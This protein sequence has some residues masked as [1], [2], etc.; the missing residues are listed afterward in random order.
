M[1]GREVFTSPCSRCRTPRRGA[2]GRS[3]GPRPG[4][5]AWGWTKSWGRLPA[6]PRSA[7]TERWCEGSH[8]GLAEVSTLPPPASVRR[9]HTTTNKSSRHRRAANEVLQ[10]SNDHR[11]MVEWWTAR[12]TT[13]QKYIGRNTSIVH[14]FPKTCSTPP[15]CSCTA[16]ATVTLPGERRGRTGKRHS[17]TLP[18]KENSDQAAMPLQPRDNR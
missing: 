15:P 8:P 16:T 18:P 3:P 14:F 1:A 12:K 5:E 10:G 2:A 6:L 17:A 4:R 11:A 7:W 9:C 13:I